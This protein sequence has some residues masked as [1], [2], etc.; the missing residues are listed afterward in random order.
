[1]QYSM[2]IFFK[3]FSCYLQSVTN[4]VLLVDIKLLSPE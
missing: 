1:M 4:K 3:M 2:K